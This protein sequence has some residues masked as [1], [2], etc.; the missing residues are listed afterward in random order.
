MF[1]LVKTL[2]LALNDGVCMLSGEQTGLRTGDLTRYNSYGELEEAF[3]VQ[4]EYFFKRMVKVCEGVEK[5]HQ[6]KMPSPFL[7]SVQAI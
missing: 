3:K 1:N 7:S 2:E 6:I 4:L 5:I